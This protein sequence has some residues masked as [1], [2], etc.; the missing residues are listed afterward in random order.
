[1]TIIEGDAT[2]VDVPAQ[3]GVC[4]LYPDVLAAL[5][6]KLEK[7]DRFASYMHGVDG[8]AMSRNGDAWTWRKPQQVAM[9]TQREQVPRQ[10]YGA[11]WGGR[12]YSGPVCNSPGCRMCNSIRSQLR[13]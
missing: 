4:Y 5:K 9:Q 1:V 3:V 8:L 12:T 6:P 11:V 7:L 13:R 10:Q 2:Q